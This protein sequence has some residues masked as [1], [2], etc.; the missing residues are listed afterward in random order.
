MVNQS[1]KSK[2]T[3]KQNRAVR[4]YNAKNKKMR[5]RVEVAKLFCGSAAIN[6]LRQRPKNLFFSDAKKG[7]R[8][9][10]KERAEILKQKMM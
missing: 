9:K 3:R 5:W 7:N 6:A 4:T 2:A 8:A 1:I 10:V